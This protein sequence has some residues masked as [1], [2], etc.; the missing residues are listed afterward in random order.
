[1]DHSDLSESTFMENYIGLIETVLLS[2]RNICYGPEIKINKLKQ[3]C[4]SPSR[5]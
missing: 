2:T 4:I 3:L 1:M 5:P